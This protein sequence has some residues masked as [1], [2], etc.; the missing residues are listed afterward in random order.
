MYHQDFAGNCFEN[1]REELCRSDGLGPN[2]DCSGFVIASISKVIGK[3]PTEWKG[4]RHVRDF[5]QAAQQN[6]HGLAVTTPAVGDLLI[7]PRIYDIAGERRTV[8]AHIGIITAIE[9]EKPMRWIH[10]NPQSG[11]VEEGVVLSA[12]IP[13][14]AISLAGLFTADFLPERLPCLAAVANDDF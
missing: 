10:A 8:P 3:A 1:R 12:G 6:E 9:E 13:L 11:K 14:G 2:F 5:W 4:P 7:T